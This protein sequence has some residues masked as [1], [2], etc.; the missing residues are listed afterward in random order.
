MTSNAEATKALIERATEG[1]AEAL[2][3]LL[4][5]A[6][7]ELR[8]SLKIDALWNRS[9]DV[10]DVLQVT[11]LE[12]FLRIRHLDRRDWEGFLAWLRRVAEHNLIDAIRSL[13]RDK[14]PNPRHRDTQGP[15]GESARTLLISI[16]GDEV[17]VGSQ[18]AQ[19]EELVRLQEAIAALPASYRTVVEQLDLQERAVQELAEQM[20]RSTGAIYMLRSRA[21]D[22]LR[23][24]LE[25]RRR[26]SES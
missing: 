21:H 20:G 23:E 4:Q 12:A 15:K 3:N 16:A 24:L 14:R 11:W 8:K 10:E 22:R 13:E 19:A 26:Q 1:D 9:L 6:A 7:P 25:L 5:V 2:E 17:T 18:A